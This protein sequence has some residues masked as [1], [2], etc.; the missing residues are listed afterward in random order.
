MPQDRQNP[1]IVK[2]PKLL[3]EVRNAF[4]TKHYSMKTEETYVHWIKRFIFFLDKLIRLRIIYGEL[5]LGEFFRAAGGKCN[6]NTKRLDL[7]YKE[8]VD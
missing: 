8:L 6:L 5:H 7:P 1:A 3:D 2:K 4:R